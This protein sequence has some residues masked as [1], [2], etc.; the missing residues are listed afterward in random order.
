MIQ[1]IFPEYDDSNARVHLAKRNETGEYPIDSIWNPEEW[2]SWQTYRGIAKERFVTDFIVTFAQIDGDRYLYG[3]IFE[4]VSRDGETYQVSPVE[5]RVE[6]HSLIL[7]FE[8]DNKRST[9]FTPSYIN[10]NASILQSHVH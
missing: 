5:H 4:I 3:G 1:E 2:A 8:G 10:N 7:E 6:I 9:V